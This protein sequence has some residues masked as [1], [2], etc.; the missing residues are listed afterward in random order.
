MRPRS[1][2]LW[3]FLV[4]SAMPS[5]ADSVPEGAFRPLDR[6]AGGCFR[7]A[8]PDGRSTDEHCWEWVWE[9][10]FLR[11]R[12]VVKGPQPDYEGET[13]YGWDSET[14]QLRFWYFTNAGF[15]S[16]GVVRPDGERAVFPETVVE[17][18][19]RRELESVTTFPS[20]DSYRVVSRERV[21]GEWKELWTMELRRVPA[22]EGRGAG[23]GSAPLPGRG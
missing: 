6:L 15:F 4:V 22:S 20:P 8:F 23:H 18:G 21:D 16:T 12:H 11:D 9:G 10:R 14:R 17:G 7:G 13:L 19:R 1:G 5:G 3:A 2:I